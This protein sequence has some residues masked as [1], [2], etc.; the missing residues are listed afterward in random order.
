MSFFY[1][2]KDR[3][4]L[5]GHA[6]LIEN[7]REVASDWAK[8][9]IKHN[10]AI[11]W[12]V[13]RY[14]EADRANSNKQ[15]FRLGDLRMKRATLDHAPMNI[16]HSSRNIVGTFL[17]NE[18]VYPDE[19]NDHPY[20][21][22]V[23]AIW[24]YY[25]PEEHEMVQRANKDGS[26]YFSMEAVP[27]SLSTIGGSDDAAQ[28][29]YMGRQ[30]ESYPEEINTRSCEAIVCNNPHFVGGAL[31]IP[32]NKPGWSNANITQVA[33]YMTDQWEKADANLE[34][35]F[36]IPEDITLPT[37]YEVRNLNVVSRWEDDM[38]TLQSAYYVEQG[39]PYDYA[40][41]FD[42]ETRQRLASEGKAMKDGSYPIVNVQDLKN[43]IQAIGRAKNPS[44]A[45]A[46]IKRRASALG[47]SELIP[48]GW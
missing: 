1:E 3:I 13:G 14:V 12:V 29:A 9:I 21:E 26:L 41:S 32:P 27:E 33:K 36:D 30:H 20:I 25:F 46:H 5:G 28:Y 47:A 4:Y 24:K 22:A 37:L 19:A 11:S 40:R 42:T 48:E 38:R 6:H 8:G 18:L 15:Y 23:G 16:N 39:E 35:A 44:A 7:D 2:G 31:I 45:K 10:P 17:A 43:A 34:L